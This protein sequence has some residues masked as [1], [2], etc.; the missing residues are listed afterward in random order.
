MLRSLLLVSCEKISDMKKSYCQNWQGQQ[1][2]PVNHWISSNEWLNVWRDLL[3]RY[4]TKC[5]DQ[6]WCVSCVYRKVCPCQVG[7]GVKIFSSFASCLL[8]IATFQACGLVKNLALMTHITTDLDEL[9]ISRLCYNL[10]VEELQLIGGEELT[11]P[12][13]YLVFL[14][15][16]G[17]F[18]SIL[19]MCVACF[20]RS[21]DS[22]WS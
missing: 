4:K 7:S 11:S 17:Y 8:S 12:L 14:N 3:W 16:T 22:S 15:G 21:R 10:G 19:M 9:P 20:Q 5:S 6:T 13:N 18:C 1:I 2:L